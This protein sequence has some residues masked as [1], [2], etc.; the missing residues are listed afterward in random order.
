MY[1]THTQDRQAWLRS[2]PRETAF[3]RKVSEAKAR[4]G[5]RY[6]FHPANRVQRLNNVRPPVLK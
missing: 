5:E 3:E 6:L 1:D 4:M 2:I